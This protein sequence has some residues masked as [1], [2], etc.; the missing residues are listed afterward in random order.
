MSLE[1]KIYDCIKGAMK[2]R[3]QVALR[4]LRAIKSEILLFNTSGTGQ[5]LDQA[6][7]IKI[8]QK[9]IKQ[10]ADSLALYE[11]EGRE[12]LASKEREE[13]EVI[14]PF[15]PDQLS[16]DELKEVIQGIIDETGAQSMKDMGKVMGMAS[17]KI[18]GKA[19]N[20]TIAGM[21]KL[22]LQS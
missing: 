11:Q 22:L 4:A 18:Q 9:M 8:L 12:D 2:A 17:K 13:I 14:K 15:L 16:E 1:Q 21:V 19:D 20:K 5:T 7:E 6:G 3:E 10:R